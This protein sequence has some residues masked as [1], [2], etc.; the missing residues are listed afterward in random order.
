MDRSQPRRARVLARGITVLTTVLAAGV[1]TACAS[2]PMT[3]PPPR[4]IVVSSGQRLRADTARIDSIYSW[5]SVQ[6]RRIQEDP[7]FLIA[8]T[9]TA[10]ETTPWATIQMVGDTAR[11]QYDRAHPDIT[12]AYDVYATYHLMK[13]VGKLVDWLP[14]HENDE[15]YALER[16]IVD[17]MADA[18]L[19]GR[20][21]FDAPPYTPLDELL[22]AREAGYLDEYMLTTRAS[23]FAAEKEAWER[24]HPGRIE[25]F[26]SWFARSFRK[27]APGGAPA[28]SATAA[29]PPEAGAETAPSSGGK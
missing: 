19:L 23:E 2:G 21:S 15:G 17:R 20:A 18:W 22:F 14:G 5:L 3:A 9:P 1:G 25:E 10:R 13:K 28:A 6:S 29:P 8:S 27:D 7:S 12:T 16:A 26:R 4:P 11:Y 24:D